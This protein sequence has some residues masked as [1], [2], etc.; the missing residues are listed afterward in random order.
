MKVFSIKYKLSRLCLATI[1][2]AS[3]QIHS[4]S[5]L[6]RR[7]DDR[8]RHNYF[9]ANQL[10]AQASDDCRAVAAKGGLRVRQN[11]STNAPVLDRLVDGRTVTIENLGADG[12]V[13]ISYPVN[14]Y[15]AADYLTDC[16]PPAPPT[17]PEEPANTCRR[18][19][20]DGGLYVRREPDVNSPTVELL[21]NGTKVQIES[22]GANGW[23]PITSPNNGFVA[24][25][26]LARCSD[27]QLQTKD[28]D[29]K[30]YHNNND[31]VKVFFPVAP[32]TRDSFTKVRP[33]TRTTN[34]KGLAQF[35][36]AQLI[37]GPTETE[38]QQGLIDPIEF[39]GESTCE[40][41]FTISI[42]RKTATLQFCRIVPT[43][44]V[45]DDARIKTAIEKTLTQFPTVEEVIILDRAGNCFKDLSGKNLCLR[46]S[47]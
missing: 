23:V 14:G 42:A 2:F 34:S 41:N 11:P 5:A 17:T 28:L 7:R 9:V 32:E 47:T 22:L 40:G 19:T 13:P 46:Q 29:Y 39:T 38:Q 4:T 27:R 12:W 20:A 26:Y 10:L 25:E 15:V 35:A 8:N 33:V 21:P 18:V 16:S 6:G 24:A 45:G 1:V 44:G 30:K 3:T 31:T 43:G 36:I 37:A